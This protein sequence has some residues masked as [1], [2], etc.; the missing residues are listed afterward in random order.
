MCF[1]VDYTKIPIYPI[2]YLLK[3]DYRAWGFGDVGSSI[4]GLGFREFGLKFVL[5]TIQYTL[6]WNVSKA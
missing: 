2:F 1:W 6:A 5:G 3:G 4:Q